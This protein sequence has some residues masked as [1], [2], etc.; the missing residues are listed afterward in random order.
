MDN[1][2]TD[3]VSIFGLLGLA[4]LAIMSAF[5]IGCL[6]GFAVFA[7][8]YLAVLLVRTVGYLRRRW[9]LDRRIAAAR[10]AAL[11]AARPLAPVHVRPRVVFAHQL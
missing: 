7:L 11:P 8:V 6:A 10:A 5:A 4:A 3:T 1:Q 9:A 2:P